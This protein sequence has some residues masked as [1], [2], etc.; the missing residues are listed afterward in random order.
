MMRTQLTV[1]SSVGRRNPNII[2]FSDLSLLMTSTD[3]QSALSYEETYGAV[4]TTYLVALRQ[5]LN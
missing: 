5:I 4:V 2:L 3:V 1:A